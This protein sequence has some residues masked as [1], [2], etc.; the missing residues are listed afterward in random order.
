MLLPNIGV[1]DMGDKDKRKT[2]YRL[3]IIYSSYA[4]MGLYL[5]SH[6]IQNTCTMHENK[7]TKSTSLT[8]KNFNRKKLVIRNNIL[9]TTN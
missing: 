7:R 4:V 6:F 5:L 2:V 1:N 3:V 8:E 9:T